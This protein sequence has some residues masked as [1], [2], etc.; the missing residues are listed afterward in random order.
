MRE[1]VALIKKDLPVLIFESMGKALGRTFVGI[2][3]LLYT[4]SYTLTV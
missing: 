3:L 2:P 1:E 4:R